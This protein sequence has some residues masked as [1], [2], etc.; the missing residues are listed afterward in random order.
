MVKEGRRWVLGWVISQFIIIFDP[1]LPTHGC[2][3]RMGGGVSPAIWEDLAP[4]LV[5]YTGQYNGGIEGRRVHG[6]PAEGIGN[7][8]G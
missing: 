8:Q 6:C 3:L 1:W 2:W 7:D 4:G 5:P